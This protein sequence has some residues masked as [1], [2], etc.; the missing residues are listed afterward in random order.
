MF[1]SKFGPK[2]LPKTCLNFKSI[3]MATLKLV[4]IPNKVLKDGTHRIRIAIGHKKETRYISTR[5]KVEKITQFKDGQVINIPDANI[6]NKKL[7]NLLNE[8]GDMLDIIKSIHLYSCSQLREML[9]NGFKSDTAA[10]FQ[11]VSKE[12]ISELCQDG[13]ENYAALLERNCRYFTDFCKGE[14]LLSSITPQLILNYSRHL[15]NNYRLNETS[16]GMFMSRTRT[17]INRGKRQQL[18]K[19]DIEPMAYYKIP[20]SPE[21]EL[22]ISIS[23]LKKIRDCNPDRKKFIVARDIF[24]LS[25]YLAGVN[26]IDLM[27]YDFRNTDRFEYV[28]IKSRNQ[29]QG[30]KRISFTIP[31]EAGTIIKRWMNKNTGRLDFGYILAYRNF[32][33]YMTRTIKRLGTDLDIKGRVVYYSARKSFVQHGFELGISLE[34][35]EYCIGQTMK[36][37]RPI[38]NYL[39]IMRTHADKAIRQILDNLK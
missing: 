11:S 4:I 8:Y 6:I 13:R 25:Y 17:I 28:R 7:R 29:K 15:K 18:V 24:I 23:D 14:M 33:Q 31:P 38:F 35:L 2:G 3:I 12:Y 1:R 9:S 16:I 19:Y 21:R 36:T 39:R 32:S 30:D 20:S 27:S 10:T 26:M 5:Y 37:N 34:I 22:D